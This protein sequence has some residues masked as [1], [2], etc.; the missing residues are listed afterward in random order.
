MMLRPQD[1]ENSLW[2]R[3]CDEYEA[4]Q[5]P[6]PEGY[7]VKEATVASAI[8]KESTILSHF[9]VQHFYPVSLD[10]SVIQNLPPPPLPEVPEVI[11]PK[12]CSPKNYLETY[13]FPV[14][15]PGMVE[16][17]HQAKKEKCF[18]RRRT[19]FI[20]C[21]FLTEWLY[22]PRP[23]VPL[24]LL[25]SEEAAAL[26]IQSFW[27]G[28]RIRCDPEVQELRQWQKQLREDKHIHERVK[29]FWNKQ[30]IKVKCKLDD[31]GEELPA[32]PLDLEV[33]LQSPTPP[34]AVNFTT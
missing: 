26:I 3:I 5:P 8:P 16:L 31:F 33:S 18:E 19:K 29:E 9:N 20:A 34:S 6:F 12:T 22:N 14:L 13:I 21:D 17:L 7:K 23:P 2:E 32:D 15:L 24:S 25:L 1:H 27:W 4:E 28:Y 11:D 10:Y 30:E